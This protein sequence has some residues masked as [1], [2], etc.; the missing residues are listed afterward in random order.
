L[1]S[2]AACFAGA[3]RDRLVESSMTRP[4]SRSRSAFSII[5]LLIVLTIIAI[6]IALIF[7]AVQKVRTISDRIYCGNHLRQIGLALHNF[8][9]VNKAFPPGTSG[10][11]PG[12]SGEMSDPPY[13]CF[14]W[15]SH[16]LPYIEQQDVRAKADQAYAVQSW[17][18]TKPHPCD[19]VL[20]MYI[21]PS[22]RRVLQAHYVG[23]GI[24]VG[25]ASYQGVNGT[26]LRAFDGIFYTKS[27]TRLTDLQGGISN[28]LMVGE[29]PPSKDLWFGWWYSG[30]GQWDFSQRDPNSGSC[31]VILG[32]RELNIKSVGIP[33]MDNC[34]PGPY[35]YTPG[36]LTNYADQFHFWS[37][38]GAGCN[39]L[40]ADGGVRFLQ[41]TA[42]P[43][44]PTMAGRS[45][46]K[47]QINLPN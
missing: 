26:D 41:Y 40:F 7:S 28:T 15:F 20:Q 22:D 4:P 43:L 46:D 10:Q 31:D 23:A 13:T 5:E 25:F 12:A 32:V 44:L 6:L 36:Q 47:S 18:Y 19:L 1:N 42:D 9:T 16:I 27:Q 45:A 37:L 8:H 33:E 39:W 11:Q 21:C 29:R 35:H 14:S 3:R 2:S 34:P 17:P 38:H 30:A 24:T